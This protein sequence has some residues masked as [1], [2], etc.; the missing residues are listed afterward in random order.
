MTLAET[1]CLDVANL[2]VAYGSVVAV[3]DASVRLEPGELVAVVGANGAGKTSL[4]SAIVGLE[5]ARAGTVRVFGTPMTGMSHERMLRS[6]VALV[7]E[8]RR[9]LKSLTVEENL[10]VSGITRPRNERHEQMHEL[11][12]RFEVLGRRRDVAAGHLSGGEAQ[13]LAVARALMARPS[14]LLLDE[15]TLGLSP[16]LTHEVFDL[17]KA[18]R[19]DGLSL[20]VVEQNARR[21]VDLSDRTYV[22]R[23]GRV[24]ASGT[25]EELGSQDLFASFV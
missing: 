18:L 1:S 10:V 4:L 14:I 21:I 12:E 22:M 7:P 2:R 8:H 15:P 3:H 13:Q 17:M 19:D 11:M 24:V 9:I 5:P 16:Q 6:G 25:P 20:L 23:N